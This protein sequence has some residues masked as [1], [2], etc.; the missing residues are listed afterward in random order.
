M[1]GEADTDLHRNTCTIVESMRWQVHSISQ[2]R[3]ATGILAEFSATPPPPPAAFSLPAMY[4]VT[5]SALTY[6][7]IKTTYLKAKRA[8][9]DQALERRSPRWG[10]L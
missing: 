3:E 6:K 8:Y 1:G 5:P 9:V 4:L 2:Q 10:T 7:P